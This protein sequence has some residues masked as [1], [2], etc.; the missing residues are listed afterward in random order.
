MPCLQDGCAVTSAPLGM[1]FF[2]IFGLVVALSSPGCGSS[3]ATENLSYGDSAREAYETALE[4]FEDGDCLSAEPAFRK[5]AR[6]FPYSR[7]AALAE[8]RVADCLLDQAKYPEA[9]SAYRRFV[10]NRP[11][12]REV[13]YARFKVAESYFEQIPEDF[14]LSPPSYELDQGPTHE[15]LRQ[16]RRFVLDFPDDPRVENAN[17]LTRNALTMLAQHELYVADYYLDDGHPEAAVRRL[18]TLLEAYAGSG[19]EAEAMLLLGR[20]YLD[21]GDRAK[22]RSTFEDLRERYPDS[23]YAQQSGA[24]LADL[25]MAE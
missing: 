5:V 24:Y 21:M 20:V 6:E 2:K 17:E 23:G 14:I 7:M 22:A 25:G 8:L 15:A 11:S 18:N 9:I 16:L 4:D 19:I 1:R 12:H 3:Q 13:P 10:R